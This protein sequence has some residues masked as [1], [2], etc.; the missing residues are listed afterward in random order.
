MAVSIITF[1]VSLLL[2]TN[3]DKTTHLMQ[4]TERHAWI[5]AWNINYSLGLDGISVLFV[6]LSTLITIL[7]I[8]ISWKSIKMKV[9]EFYI[10]TA[11]FGRAR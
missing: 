7:C 1:L 10:S 4:F 6:L 5:P 8:L 11:D 9:K 2:F 3:F